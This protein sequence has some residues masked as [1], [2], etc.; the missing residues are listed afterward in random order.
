MPSW[1]VNISTIA[2]PIF[3]RGRTRSTTPVEMTF[4]G[5]PKITL[6]S[7]DSA[8]TKPPYFLIARTPSMPSSPMPVRI[9]ATQWSPYIRD[10]DVRRAFTEG[11]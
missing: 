5:I 4:F 3:Q 8:I 10:A 11:T 6:V 7:S 2:S 9:T 1:R